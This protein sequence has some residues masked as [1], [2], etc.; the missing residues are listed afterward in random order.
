VFLFT[1]ETVVVDIIFWGNIR[2]NSN[3]E[4]GTPQPS[5]LYTSRWQITVFGDEWAIFNELNKKQFELF[6]RMSATTLLK[7]FSRKTMTRYLSVEPMPSTLPVET[8][9]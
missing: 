9:R 5:S 7:S 6:F 4:Q 2:N 8:T 3:T 1:V